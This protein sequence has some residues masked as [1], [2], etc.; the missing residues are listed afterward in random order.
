MEYLSMFQERFGQTGVYQHFLKDM[1]PPVN[2]IYFDMVCILIAACYLVFR[3][4]DGV[5]ITGYHRRVRRRQAEEQRERREAERQLRERETEVR[6]REEKIY[7]FLDAC[8]YY[9]RN[10]G[11]RNAGNAGGQKGGFFSRIGRKNF[12]LSDRKGDVFFDPAVMAS[13]YDVQMQATEESRR[14]EEAFEEQRRKERERVDDSM[15]ILEEQMRVEPEILVGEAA[16]AEVDLRF[17]KRRARALKAERREKER[18]RRAAEKKR[19]K[20]G[21]RGVGGKN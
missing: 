11:S 6:G 9:F 3:V 10:R 2:N 1:P 19:K 4:V 15:S 20:E 17:E 18:A 8:E 12:L 16:D 5:R 7:H 21:K 14:Q 13:D